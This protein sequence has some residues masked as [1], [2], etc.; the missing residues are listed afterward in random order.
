VTIRNFALDEDCVTNQQFKEFVL[1]TGYKTE[2][3]LYQ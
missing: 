1:Q 2:A 3:E